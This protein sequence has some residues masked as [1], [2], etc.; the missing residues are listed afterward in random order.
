MSK[1]RVHNLPVTP[2]LNST[3]RRDL[4]KTLVHPVPETKSG[5]ST[6]QGYLSKNS[7]HHMAATPAV[8]STSHGYISNIYVDPMPV[9]SDFPS[10]NQDYLSG[11]PLHVSVQSSSQE[12]HNQNVKETKRSTIGPEMSQL[13]NTTIAFNPLVNL[14]EQAETCFDEEAFIQMLKKTATINLMTCMFLVSV[15]P[16]VILGMLNS[17]CDQGRGDCDSFVY[18]Y[19]IVGYFRIAAFIAQIVIVVKGVIQPQW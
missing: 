16:I 9:T 3:K 6:S 17:N 19:Q 8:Q 1:N 12:K 14:I 4:F 15:V 18:Y 7:V 5:Q 2:A 13:V 10:T 11:H